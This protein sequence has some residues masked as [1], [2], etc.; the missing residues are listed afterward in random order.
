[1][2]KDFN[3]VADRKAA[4][5]IVKEELYRETRLAFD[6]EPDS[7]DEEEGALCLLEMMIFGAVKEHVGHRFGRMGRLVDHFGRC[8]FEPVERYAIKIF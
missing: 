2:I 1:M 5:E 4:H 3:S 6:F 8:S 7:P